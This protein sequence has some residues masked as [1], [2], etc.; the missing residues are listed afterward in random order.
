MTAFKLPPQREGE[1]RQL[2]PHARFDIPSEKNDW[3]YQQQLSSLIQEWFLALDPKK[4][5]E[6]FTMADSFAEFLADKR[7][8][9]KL[10]ARRRDTGEEAVPL[11]FSS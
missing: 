6:I 4:N 3:E 2:Y 9:F 1:M 11:Q 8:P 10:F 7:I 5:Q